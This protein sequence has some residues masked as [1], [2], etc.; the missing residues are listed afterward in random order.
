MNQK[1]KD[2]ITSGLVYGS[3]FFTVA[4]L[5]LI[6]GFIFINGIPNISMHFLTSSYEDETMYVNV[7]VTQDTNSKEN[8]AASLGMSLALNDENQIVVEKIDSSSTTK[9]A[10]DMSGASAKL[11]KGDIIS[12]VDATDLEETFAT[13]D[14]GQILTA[15]SDSLNQ[16]QNGT[17]R[18]KIT[19][20]GGGIVPMLI[21]T[22]YMIVL[23][24]VVAAPIGILS[25]VYLNEYAKQGKVVTL[26]RFAIQNLSGIPSIIYGLFGAIF[27]VQI[28]HMSYSV[29]A[30]ALTIAII[31]L[32]VIISTT[33]ETLKAIPRGYRESSLGLGATKLQTIYK[34]IL[35]N[36]LPGILVAV[37]LSVGR[38]VGES[39]ALLLTSGTV[40]SIPTAL[41]GSKAS[42][43]T[44]TIKAYT[45]LKEQGNVGEACA[46]GV[47][48]IVLIVVLN[49]LS[50]IVTNRYM[51]KQSS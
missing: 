31:L 47:V 29:L 22:L 34:I 1:T 23:S 51:A 16:A 41:T 15:F 6:L 13:G 14:E 44:L 3:S 32:P 11:K 8:P 25:A 35:P 28:C 12:K 19:R 33:E 40:A 20:T 4:I 27:F 49:M 30:G 37:I 24:L 46:I 21:T 42:G 2:A 10:V 9:Q 17:V 26:I 7:P 48:L 39:A 50:K 36:A 38:V 5:V 18:L 43:A 45:A